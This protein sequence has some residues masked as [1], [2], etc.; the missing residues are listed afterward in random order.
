MNNGKGLWNA[1]KDADQDEDAYEVIDVDLDEVVG[2][3][4]FIPQ[5]NWLEYVQNVSVS[6]YYT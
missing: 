6:Y 3:L 2:P 1:D 4:I 5:L